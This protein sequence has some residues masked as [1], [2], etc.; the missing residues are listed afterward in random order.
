MNEGEI[1]MCIS[2]NIWR[3]QLFRCRANC[4]ARKLPGGRSLHVSLT[5]KVWC[6]YLLVY[7]L[8][9][10]SPESSDNK[11]HPP[12]RQQTQKAEWHVLFINV[13]SPPGCVRSR[14]GIRK[15]WHC[16]KKKKLTSACKTPPSVQQ[17]NCRIGPKLMPQKKKLVCLPGCLDNK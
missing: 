11:S 15:N 3:L 1:C 14:G 7:S 9:P 2:A 5:V 8:A 17:L 16:F 10:V 6:L 13:M 4:R 12:H